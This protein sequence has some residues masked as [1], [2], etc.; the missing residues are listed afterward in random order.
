MATRAHV[1]KYKLCRRLGP[2]VF[3]KCQSQKFLMSQ[4]TPS[5]SAMRRSDFGIQ[6]IEKQKVRFMYG[7]GERQFRNY[8]DQAMENKK[9]GI[10]PV[11]VLNVLLERR[12]D[13]TVY[14]LGLASTR[15][16][17]RQMVSH[18]HI[19]VNGRKLNIAS[20]Q[21]QE[22]DVIS[23]R[24]ESRKSPLFR[25]LETKLKNYKT[26]DWLAWKGDAMTGTVRG[27]PRQA[28]AF[29]NLQAVIE[30]YSR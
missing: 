17:A 22:N 4:G 20:Y 24:E 10:T 5:R 11:E 3:D 25:D 15:A 29:L 12:L 18:G 6:L 21:T 26:P 1:K 30:F 19:T 2:G 28:D 27:E 8:V 23:V 7:M 16:L 14:R 9:K 13:N